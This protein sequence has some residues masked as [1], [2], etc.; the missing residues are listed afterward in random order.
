RTGG[1]GGVTGLGAGISLTLNDAGCETRLPTRERPQAHDNTTGFHTAETHPRR[2]AM[3]DAMK[4]KKVRLVDDDQAILTSMQA[5]F[6]PTGATIDTANNGNKAV[7][8]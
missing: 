4:D 1:A 6:E 7:E 3:S 8:L 2:R 5:A